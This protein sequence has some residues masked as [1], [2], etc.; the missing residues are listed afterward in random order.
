MSLCAKYFFKGDFVHPKLYIYTGFK[1]IQATLQYF[2]IGTANLLVLKR[3]SL[4]FQ[5]ILHLSWGIHTFNLYIIKHLKMLSIEKMI[6]CDN[7]NGR[8][9]ENMFISLINLALLVLL[10]SVA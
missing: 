3:L 6:P 1:R 2:I 4:L 8:S 10:Q 9:L 7:K 5:V